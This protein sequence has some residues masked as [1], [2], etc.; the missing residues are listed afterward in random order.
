MRLGSRVYQRLVG[1]ANAIRQGFLP[2]HTAQSR[3]RGARCDQF[4][5][6][7]LREAPPPS[8]TLPP[9]ATI[10]E[11]S[12]QAGSGGTWATPPPCSS[13]HPILQGGGGAKGEHREG[14]V[15]TQ[16]RRTAGY[17]G[18]NRISK[19]KCQ[20]LRE[21]TRKWLVLPINM[22]FSPSEEQ[23]INP[24]SAGET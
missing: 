20:G 1:F 24:L 5:P 19:G 14:R 7:P 9:A 6:L 22:S 11:A 10:T 3:A 21:I 16:F 2:T 12:S 23:S 17:K 4:G 18:S 8:H 13:S 15:P